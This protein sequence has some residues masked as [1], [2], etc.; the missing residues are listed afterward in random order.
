MAAI[1]HLETAARLSPEAAQPVYKLCTLMKEMDPGRAQVYCGQLSE[2]K[3]K[4]QAATLAE[5]PKVAAEHAASR[6]DWDAA[7]RNYQESIATCADC[8]LRAELHKALGFAYCYSDDARH[9]GEELRLALNLK[10]DDVETRWALD[11]LES[12]Q[13]PE[14][15]GVDGKHESGLG[16]GV[17]HGGQPRFGPGEN[18]HDFP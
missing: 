16:A 1:S 15:P 9:C 13:R 11:G 7:I 12:S 10:P 5:V 14:G 8:G 17:S 2:I 3:R 6:R 18:A 4:Q